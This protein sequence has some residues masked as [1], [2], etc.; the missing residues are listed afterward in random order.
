M[1][2]SYSLADGPCA[3]CGSTERA[4]GGFQVSRFTDPEYASKPFVPSDAEHPLFDAKMEP[5]CSI[6]CVKAAAVL[7]RKLRK[8]GAIG[9]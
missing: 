7:L 5:L 4:R 2:Y 1:W 3:S 6:S 8:A 9:V